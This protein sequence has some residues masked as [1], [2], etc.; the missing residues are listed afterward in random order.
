M[1]LS[2]F[3][4]GNEGREVFWN[5]ENFEGLLFAFTAIAMAIFVYGIYR[6]WQMWTAIGKPESQ[7]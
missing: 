7:K 1:E 3:S 2:K 6:R 5:A 4:V